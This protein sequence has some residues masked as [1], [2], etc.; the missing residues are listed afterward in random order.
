MRLLPVILAFVFLF[1]AAGAH[2]A[3]A[4][5]PAYRLAR[6]FREG[7]SGVGV[8]LDPDEARCKER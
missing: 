2:A 8:A 1:P 3:S 7:L 5:E 4:K 6:V